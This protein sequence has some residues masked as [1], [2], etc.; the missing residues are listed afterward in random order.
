VQLG[1]PNVIKLKSHGSFEAKDNGDGFI[2]KSPDGT[3][4]KI[5]EA[6]NGS[7]FKTLA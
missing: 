2:C 4:F 1:D 6:N 3:S 7:L 5:T